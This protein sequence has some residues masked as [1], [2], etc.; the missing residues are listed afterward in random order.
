M[1]VNNISKMSKQ[2]KNLV[3]FQCQKNRARLGGM[4]ISPE[5]KPKRKFGA[6]LKAEGEGG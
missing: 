4:S 3:Y 1:S 2:N 6:R 5:P